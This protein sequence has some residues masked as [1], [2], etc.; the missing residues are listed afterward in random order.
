MPDQPSP[1]PWWHRFRLSGRALM[2]LVL[3]LGGRLGWIVHR[4]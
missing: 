4:A 1:K 2:I 3:V